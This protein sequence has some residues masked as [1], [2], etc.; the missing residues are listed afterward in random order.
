[1]QILNHFTPSF[2]VSMKQYVE[3]PSC[4][5]FVAVKYISVDRSQTPWS[6][7]KL[8]TA[9]PPREL[10][11]KSAR[12]V[13]SKDCEFEFRQERRENFSSRVNFLCWLLFGVHSTPHVTAVARKRL[14]SFC[15][16]C[17]WQVTPKHAYIL[18]PTK[19]G[20]ADNAA[21]QAVWELIRK[22]A[23]TKLVGE[24][25]ATVVSDR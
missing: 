12:L 16:K 1:M 13:I 25:L 3:Y 20:W 8:R 11:G 9:L 10:V 18:D 2:I 14:R 21:V 4:V 15:Q 23:H 7:Q 24:H 6:S 22:R 5:I 19:S 17:R